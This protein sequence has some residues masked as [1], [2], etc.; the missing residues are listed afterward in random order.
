MSEPLSITMERVD[1]LLLLVAQMEPME[2]PNLLDSPCRVTG[3]WPGL[4]PAG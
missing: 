2:L 1:A 3:H 4:S